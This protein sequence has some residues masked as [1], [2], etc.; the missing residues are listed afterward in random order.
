MRVARSS[1]CTA[2][3]ARR[4]RSGCADS[5]ATPIASRSDHGRTGMSSRPP[6]P[7]A[8]CVTGERPAGGSKTKIAVSAGSSGARAVIFS[9]CSAVET[10]ATFASES[11][12]MCRDWLGG[13]RRVDGHDGRAQRED[14][15]VGQRPLEA[16]LGED[17]HPVAAT[18][19]ELGQRGG[20]LLDAGLRLG[21]RDVVPRAVPLGSE[22]VGPGMLREGGAVE[23]DQGHR[24]SLGGSAVEGRPS[25]P[26]VGTCP[27]A[28]GAVGPGP[29]QRSGLGP[30][31]VA[32]QLAPA[33]V[34][35]LARC[36]V[37]KLAGGGRSSR[38]ALRGR[39]KECPPTREPCGF[40]G[41]WRDLGGG[42]TC[43][44]T[45]VPMQKE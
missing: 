41:S 34:R 42:L 2:S 28:P 9:S 31:R 10:S 37:V 16:A 7:P 20:H 30:E 32:H 18:D 22:G 4:A 8:T 1:G 23:L 38:A 29:V 24:V 13:E 6:G 12:R 40:F 11:A 19:A 26:E 33:Q 36:R 35:A 5:A 21:R 17:G 14:A 43:T 45:S 27:V 39:R 3:P 44:N 15:E 25:A